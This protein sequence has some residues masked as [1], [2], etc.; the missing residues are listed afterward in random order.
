[1]NCFLAI[2]IGIFLNWDFSCC[3]S[4]DDITMVL[5]LLLSI[6]VLSGVIRIVND[7]EYSFSL[8]NREMNIFFIS[9]RMLDL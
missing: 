3:H 4:C 7:F 6:L 9:L 8:R 1:M 2:N 5:S